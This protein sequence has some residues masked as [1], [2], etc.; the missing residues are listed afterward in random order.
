MSDEWKMMIVSPDPQNR[1]N[2]ARILRN[3]GFDPLGTDT[4]KQ[5][6]DLLEVQEVAI[7]FCERHCPD[8][9]YRDIVASAICAPQ[10]KRPRV[11]LMSGLMPPEEY[12]QARRSGVFD[13]IGLPC[14]PAHVEWTIILAKREERNQAKHLLGVAAMKQ[15]RVKSATV[16]LR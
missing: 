13:I 6:R 2:L 3:Q 15:A 8:G 10:K 12:Q 14:R 16:I 11:V 5:C 1:G 7:I 9:D 4:V